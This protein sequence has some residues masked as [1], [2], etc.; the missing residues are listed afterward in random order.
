MKRSI[1]FYGCEFLKTA[2]RAAL[3]CALSLWAGGIFAHPAYAGGKQKAL[4]P[5]HIAAA[6]KASGDPAAPQTPDMAQ[7]DVWAKAHLSRATDLP[8]FFV[9]ADT[10]IHGIP[11]EW[12]PVE[13]TRR[14]DNNRSETDFEGTDPKTGL[15]VRVECTKYSDYPVVEWV[16]WF[17]NTGQQATP[18]LR[19]I[20]ALDGTFSGSKP[21][22]YSNNGDFYSDTGYTPQV[23]SIVPGESVH[24]APRGGRP[25]DHAF[26][27]YRIIFDHSG[28][29]MAIGWPA[30]WAV[31]FQGLADGVHVRAAQEV[32][33]LKLFPGE[34]IRTPRIT[35]LTWSGDS[36]RAVNLWRRW[37]LA[38]IMPRP[39]GELMKTLLAISG[40]DEGEE[41]TAATEQNQIKYINQW[42]QLGFDFNV[43]W[44][45]AGWYPCGGH[46][47]NT[48]SW[49][50]DP[51]RFPHGMMPVSECATRNGANLLVWFE[52]ERVRGGTELYYQHPD[53]LLK[54]RDAE[55]SLLFLGNPQ[56]RQWLTD[57]V[58]DVIRNDRIKIYRQDFN[59]EPLDYWRRNDAEDR[60][61]MNENL[62]VQGYL[63]YW[64]DLRAR[65]PGLWIDSCAS[66]GRRNDL[67]TMRRAVPL[68]YSDYG[69]GDAPVKLSFHQTL[70][71]WLL[72]FKDTTLSWDQ[73][74]KGRYNSQVDSYAFHCGMA[75]MLALGIDI[76]DE[77]YDFPFA[78]KMVGV[79][80]RIADLM[81]YGDYYPQTPFGRSNDL[82]VAWQ[83]DSP[84]KGEGYLQGIRLPK[85]PQESLTIHPKALD[86]SATYIFENPETGESKTIAGK[87]LAEKGF[88]FTQPARSGAIWIYRKAGAK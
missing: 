33:N 74:P 46:W 45:D 50:P 32:T 8:I 6:L 47:P 40:T 88:T 44:I 71:E 15:R 2:A 17:E 25:S 20:Q 9:Y 53:W 3:L 37:Y 65:N 67:E 4:A 61:G 36:S 42:K 1:P 69:Y 82:W 83:F 80:R 60:Q 54:I 59:F 84:E 27:Y 63:Q 66:G 85:C 38:H 49:E 58:S 52:P 23:K 76:K 68:H 26:P 16:A 79:W 77:H 12:R 56:C 51:A 87:D 55:D 19:D 70:F 39:N 22:I 29:S 34:K 24:Y 48:G 43:W 73:T 35:L 86:A 7:S 75:P 28:L 21:Q 72:Y 31:H 14:I 81:L 64:D 30:Q 11:I 78:K 57:H 18:I 13:N 41:F 10:P 62:H 5:T